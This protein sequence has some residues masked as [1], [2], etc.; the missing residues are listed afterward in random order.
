M[1][2]TEIF[3]HIYQAVPV[4]HYANII[5]YAL[6]CTKWS[7]SQFKLYLIEQVSISDIR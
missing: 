4:L 7:I 5:Y 2:R 3:V 6:N 1:D